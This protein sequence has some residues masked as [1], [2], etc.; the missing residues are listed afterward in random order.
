M[1]GKFIDSLFI[2]QFIIH[3]FNC[4]YKDS[5][6][7]RQVIQV[8]IFLFFYYLVTECLMPAGLDYLCAKRWPSRVAGKSLSQLGYLGNDWISSTPH[9]KRL[10][11]EVSN[12]GIKYEIDNMLEK[13]NLFP[14]VSYYQ[15][16]IMA[17]IN[18][19]CW[20]VYLLHFDIL[21]LSISKACIY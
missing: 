10:R 14:S 1:R 5:C 16:Y 12:R 17:F 9:F 7:W 15:Y 18:F 20:L 2:D 21:R 6:P 3:L 8:F 11:Q 4:L 13:A 19:V